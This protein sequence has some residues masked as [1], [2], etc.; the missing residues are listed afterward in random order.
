MGK[1]C[2]ISMKEAGLALCFLFFT[3]SF[4]HIVSVGDRVKMQGAVQVCPSGY[5]VCF[6][7][8]LAAAGV[9]SVPVLHLFLVYAVCL[10]PS[11]VVPVLYIVLNQLHSSV[12]VLNEPLRHFRAC[13]YIGLFF[14]VDLFELMFQE[15]NKIKGHQTSQIIKFFQ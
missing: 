11:Q 13:I 9:K 14:L 15:R 5:V 12:T 4:E 3:C 8:V 1:D 2:Y 7:V 6:C 10:I